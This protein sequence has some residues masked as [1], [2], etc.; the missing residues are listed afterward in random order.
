MHMRTRSQ[1]RTPAGLGQRA[2]CQ[3]RKYFATHTRTH[4]RT[5][6][7]IGLCLCYSH[8]HMKFLLIPVL[9]LP[10]W[11]QIV[12]VSVSLLA[13][14]TWLA[15]LEHRVNLWMRIP[16]RV[17]SRIWI[18]I[19]HP[20]RPR[21]EMEAEAEAE[22]RQLQQQQA[23]NFEAFVAA[24]RSTLRP[25]CSL[26]TRPRKWTHSARTHTQTHTLAVAAM[27]HVSQNIWLLRWPQFAL[28]YV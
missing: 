1:T 24:Q 13:G 2:L 25:A 27:R 18:W 26:A 3:A 14:F 10:K 19:W 9:P 8:L 6:S 15:W 7:H 20:A 22:Q 11:Q 28:R 23:R 4:T 12:S 17:S 5:H 16:I 21:P